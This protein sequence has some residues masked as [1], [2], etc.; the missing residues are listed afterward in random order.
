MLYANA[1]QRS[2]SEFYY[3]G[4]PERRQLPLTLLVDDI[5]GWT[6][7]PEFTCLFDTT[8][9][10]FY[11]DRSSVGA[12]SWSQSRAVPLRLFLITQWGLSSRG[13]QNQ[14]FHAFPLVA[15]SNMRL[16]L[17]RLTPFG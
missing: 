7:F 10:F 13:V 6:G 15:A 17:T 9:E 5:R 4:L 1:H 11:H 16:I 12:R 8:M 14:G 2:S 3:A